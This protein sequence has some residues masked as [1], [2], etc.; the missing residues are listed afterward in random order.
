VTTEPG[1]LVRSVDGEAITDREHRE[2]RVLAD[3]EDISITWS[4]YAPG[5][6]G[7]DPHVHREHSDAFY[8][9]DGE[10]TFR[11]GPAGEVFR[12]PA[13][14][15]VAAPPNLVHSFANEGNV[16]ARFL[17]LHAPDTG[18]VGSLR[19]R[20]DGGDPSYDQFDPPA[21]GGRPRAD[22]VVAAP[23][24]GERLASGNRVALMKGV[25]AHLC[26]A[27]WTIEG[28]FK[29]PHLHRHESGVDSFYVLEGELEMTVE[30]SVGAQPA[31]PAAS[32]TSMHVAGPGTLAA[33]P[34][35]VLHTFNHRGSGTV[36]FLNVHAPD[37][38]FADFLRGI[39][40]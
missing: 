2:L 24:E 10:L 39:S 4:R 8:V 12:M 30:D 17:N 25:L 22:A 36:R 9:L 7:P 33:V 27:E 16:D 3:H 13:G 11:L 14:G 21:D 18:F 1:I 32:A 23:G 20:R 37:E 28:P 31:E 5:E 34:R 35:G 40:D 19:A 15:F 38:G 29:G 26:L 6:R